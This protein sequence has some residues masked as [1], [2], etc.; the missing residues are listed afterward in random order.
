MRQGYRVT[1]G[2]HSRT[3][4]HTRTG[5]GE[6][7]E[8]QTS[9]EQSHRKKKMAKHPLA[10]NC[11]CSAA[12]WMKGASA[13][14]TSPSF[15]LIDSNRTGI[16]WETTAWY[17]KLMLLNTFPHSNPQILG[18]KDPRQ[19]AQLQPWEEWKA[20]SVGLQQPTLVLAALLFQPSSAL[21]RILS[22]QVGLNTFLGCL[23][24]RNFFR[25]YCGFSDIIIICIWIAW[26]MSQQ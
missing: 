5:T 1:Q 8:E 17:L 23:L 2:R 13:K 19:D 3:P 22:S 21:Q 16:S 25:V 20:T 26:C 14:D 24:R 11:L 6:L 7:A 15:R 10:C 4:L 12:F 18:I 9:E